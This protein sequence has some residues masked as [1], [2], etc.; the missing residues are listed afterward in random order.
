MIKRI[1]FFLT[2]VIILVSLNWFKSVFAQDLNNLSAEEK[3][4]LLKKVKENSQLSEKSSH[5]QS[6]EIFDNVESEQN[7]DNQIPEFDNSAK[8]SSSGV[9]SLHRDKVAADVPVKL[10]TM[11]EFDDLEPFGMELFAGLNGIEISNDISSASDYIL[12]PGDNVIIYLWGRAEKE[13][14]LTVDREGKVFV[15]QV[16]E[17]VT[18][19]LS[20]EQFT[21]KAK[22]QFGKVYSDFDLTVSLGKIRS[23]RI[24]IAGEVKK[25]GAYTV[26]SLTSMLNALYLAGG[27]NRR[28][29]MRQIALMRNSQK[30]ATT[31]LYDLLLKG[32]NSND[33]KLQTGDVIFVP[34]VGPRVAIR[35]EIK[36]SAIYELKSE[37]TAL[38]ILSLAGNPTPQA[39]LE[40]VML[41]RIAPS[42][43]WQVLDLNLDNEN[44][45]TDIVDNIT[46]QDGD[47]ITVYSIFE[48]KNNMVAVFGQVKHPGY[49]ERND[50]TTLSDIIQSSQLQNYDV[51]YDR[52]DLYRRYPDRKVEVI[53][54]NLQAL[55]N[56]D[57]TADIILND[58][59]S[60][61]I[62]SI[63]EIEWEKY[64]YVEGE[65]K[66]PG[67]YPL[68]DGMSVND[69]IFLAGSYKRGAMKHRMEIARIDEMGKIK[70]INLNMED[71]LES[72]IILKEDDHL[73]VRQ[74]PQ[75]QLDRSVSINGEV[76]YPGKYTLSSRNET[77]YQL[78]RR[79][80]GFTENAF[81]KGIVFERA[82]VTGNLERLKVA[83]VIERS[84]P[85]KIDT[86]G[87]I[88]HNNTVEYDISSMKRIVIDM[89]RILK[90][91][92]NE[93]D[94]TLEHGDNIYIPTTPSGI[95]VI[96]AVGSNGTIQYEEDKKVKDYIKY[97][98]NFIRQAD[99]NE[100][101]LIKATGEV[102]SGKGI[103]K[104]RVEIGD[105]I[106][107]PTKIEKDHNLLRTFTSV[108]SAATG[109]LTSVFIISKL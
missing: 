25:P 54:V 88:I 30:I 80:G 38:D 21:Q 42:D 72:N 46:L 41:E 53:P 60:L 40:R 70:L 33:V 22:K 15:P 98:G 109:I 74:I 105:V 29:S 3:A 48:A 92:G 59:D 51:Y 83:D 10:S 57:T 93:G 66:T 108:M 50:T 65:I 37:E 36:R 61:H 7:S 44:K 73:Y 13:Y 71:S 24:Y 104:K 62:Y 95:S 56:G 69:L 68:Y 18:W 14:N 39:H 90:T 107:V 64:V 16:G 43:E 102:I 58:R 91:K 76:L 96:G 8:S 5:Y 47:R 28:G 34:V 97:A 106:V 63:D 11:P 94:I 87:E 19:G 103:L 77:L 89:E 6:P 81:P 78:L 52:A 99:K 1:I 17:I 2:L 4:L 45:D 27:P 9:L 82:S 26:S 32:D 55:I 100:T 23:I 20:L 31:D 49:Y 12:G 67:R 86:L 101:R 84:S 75:W 35:G 79:T 85:V